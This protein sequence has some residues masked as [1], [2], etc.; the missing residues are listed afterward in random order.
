MKLSRALIFLIVLVSAF[1]VSTLLL[2]YRTL[3]NENLGNHSIMDM[4]NGLVA[5]L[6]IIRVRDAFMQ[7]QGKD[8]ITE[9]DFQT[10]R[11]TADYLHVRI[12]TFA[13]SQHHDHS[14]ATHQLTDQLLAFS[15][16]IDALLDMEKSVILSELNLVENQS[17]SAITSIINFYDTI[18]NEHVDVM[19]KNQNMIYRASL[20]SIGFLVFFS[21]FSALS[22][23]LWRMEYLGRIKRREAEE[24]VQKLA[25]TDGLT[26]LH[27]RFSFLERA[28]AFMSTPDNPALFLFDLD[29][30]KAVNDTFGHHA[31]DYLLKKVSERLKYEFEKRGG[32]V[33]R[34]GGDEFAAMLADIPND[35]SLEAFAQM[36]VEAV[37]KP[38]DFDGREFFPSLCVGAVDKRALPHP[39]EP[40]VTRML[41]KADLALYSAKGSDGQSAQVYDMALS[42]R[43]EREQK[44]KADMPSALEADEFFLHFQP[45]FCMESGNLHGFEALVRWDHE[46]SIIQPDQ[47]IP[48][49]EKSGFITDLDAWVL[50]TALEQA[51]DW[52]KNCSMPFQVSTNLS[53]QNFNDGQIVE[54]VR[55]ALR[56]T[57]FPAHL[58]TLEVT[59]SVLIGDWRKT[60][61][62]LNSL[63]KLG[64]DIA[65]DDFGTGYSSLSYLQMLNVQE[66]KIDRSFVV[67]V[68]ESTKTQI[69]LD[70]IIDIVGGLRMRL[71]VEGIETAEQAKTIAQMGGQIGQGYLFSKP[72]PAPEAQTLLRST[73]TTHAST[74]SQSA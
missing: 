52:R 35:Q 68:Q 25:F 2:Q 66:V 5:I 48:I 21:L 56:E 29:E 15:E 4:R 64:V 50:R 19:Y 20:T 33:S 44:I 67:D 16:N 42:S 34:L 14:E 60:S 24:E 1:G 26:G 39:P 36:I 61:Q 10:L 58:L 37:C 46:G 71:V 49:A 41:R 27:N 28:E 73:S 74:N 59:E 45:Q 62:I 51:Q 23:Y 70:A 43:Y 17:Q 6:D 54:T 22:V 3:Q 53:P 12:T 13:S 69:M 72:L 31:G 32:F 63:T 65:L 30:F 9:S 55:T 18:K 8:D 38:I 47:F 57:E 40:S 7:V 11:D